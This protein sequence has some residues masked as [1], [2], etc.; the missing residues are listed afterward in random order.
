MSSWSLFT[1]WHP[2]SLWLGSALLR[3][4]E[5]KDEVGKVSSERMLWAERAK[6]HA[7]WGVQARAWT[8]KESA[9]KLL[10]IGLSGKAASK[11]S[12]TFVLDAPDSVHC[13]PFLWRIET[14][15]PFWPKGNTGDSIK[16]RKA[17]VPFLPCPRHRSHI[18]VI[19]G[20]GVTIMPS[21]VFCLIQ[22]P[23]EDP[24]SWWLNTKRKPFR[25]VLLEARRRPCLIFQMNGSLKRSNE[26]SA[27]FMLSS[28]C[29]T[30]RLQTKGKMNWGITVK[31]W[32]TVMVIWLCWKK[33]VSLLEKHADLFIHEMTSGFYF[34]INGDGGNFP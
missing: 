21:N 17:L 12:P 30:V 13:S 6:L 26:T 3:H 2:E 31:F 19:P 34:T 14:N 1:R 29:E 27:F 10:F 33:N 4:I 7:W 11:H 25:W 15:K 16:S 32:G 8:L 18:I 24:S 28:S 9:K 23:W 5:V 22:N 20:S